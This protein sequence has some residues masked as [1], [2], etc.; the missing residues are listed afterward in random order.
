MT[1]SPPNIATALLDITNALIASNNSLV[2]QLATSGIDTP[3]AHS[4]VLEAY[5]AYEFAR[6]Q[7][8]TIFKSVV[9]EMARDDDAPPDALASAA[10]MLDVLETEEDCVPSK[11]EY[12]EEYRQIAQANKREQ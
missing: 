2:L 7:V 1:G 10:A 3:A 11:A 6:T 4:V 12:F 5:D 8:S 9:A